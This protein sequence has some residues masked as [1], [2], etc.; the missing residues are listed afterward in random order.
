MDIFSLHPRF[1]VEV[2]SLDLREVTA[3]THYPQLRELFERHSL[4]LFREQRM[5]E[6][7]HNEL[8][9]LFGPLE[10][11]IADSQGTRAR[12]RPPVPVLSNRTAD[13]AVATPEQSLAVQNL[14]GNQ[15]WH[16]DS[17]FL[18]TPALINAITAYV[19]PSSGGETEL[20]ST[21]AAWEDLPA[22]MQVRTRAAV[23]LHSVLPSR[24]RVNPDLLTLEE[25]D[26]HKS[27]AWNAIWPNPV[28]GEE[29]LYIAGHVY[30]VRGMTENEASEFV[31][32]LIEFCTRPEYVYSHRWRPGDV[33]I[34]DERATMHRGRPWPYEEERTL[35]SCCVSARDVDGLA[36][37]RPRGG[38]PSDAEVFRWQPA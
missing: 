16:T 21:R 3:E 10:D 32:E 8:A 25:I 6:Q 18:R 1:G 29:A 37:V 26:H 14:I 15:Q 31:T 36:G 11:R 5:N 17:T 33:M 30:G 28:T 22:A 23:F 34:W 4:L 12:S 35:A 9:S 24:I 38:P 20:V 2:R 19:V 27:Q 13:G 7:V